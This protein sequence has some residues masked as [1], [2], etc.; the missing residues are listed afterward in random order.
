LIFA[1]EARQLIVGK[2]SELARKA[3]ADP[4][5]VGGAGHHQAE[6]AGG[7]HS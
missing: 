1:G 2:H 6:A 5:Y 3:L 4:L 7:A